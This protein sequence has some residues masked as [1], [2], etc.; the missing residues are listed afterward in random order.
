MQS[1]VYNI[2]IV[3]LLLG[4]SFIRHRYLSQPIEQAKKGSLHY[5]VID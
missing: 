4:L 1:A 5:D 3:S 2:C